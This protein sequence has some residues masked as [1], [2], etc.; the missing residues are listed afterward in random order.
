MPIVRANGAEIYYE[1]NGTS[2]DPVVLIHG[3][4]VDHHSWDL[5]VPGFARA[6]QT[7][8]Y[9][10]RG[11][12]ESSGPPRTRPVRDDASDL[13]A[14]L[15]VIDLYPAHLVAHSYGGAVALRLAIDR[16][17]MVRSVSIHESTFVGLLADDPASAPEA[18][19]LLAGVRALQAL[20]RSGE[21]DLAASQFVD[22]FSSE[23]GAWQRLPADVRATFLR[24]APR[25]AEEFD[26]PDAFAPDRAACRDLLIPALLT[27]GSQSPRFLHRIM[28]ALGVLLRNS[29]VQEIPDVG[30]VPHLVRPDQYVGLVGSF[31]LERNVPST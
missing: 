4:W 3:S 6:T 25:W 28:R 22:V 27:D 5:V 26:D 1:Q 10:R 18:E 8:A 30:H 7:V 17:E 24:N 23:P 16:P 31:L 13:A 9:D 15:E 11:H 12:G 29:R 21:V 19:R 2:G 14:L 20:I